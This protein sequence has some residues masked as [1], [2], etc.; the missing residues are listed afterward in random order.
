MIFLNVNRLS[1]NLPMVKVSEIL[2]IPEQQE[3]FINTSIEDLLDCVLERELL[4]FALCIIE[5]ARRYGCNFCQPKDG[6]KEGCEEGYIKL[7]FHMLFPNE[8]NLK[9]FIKAI[10]KAFP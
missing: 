3:K 7:T 5:V 4:S 10:H 8:R 6:I 9:K 2:E 1:N